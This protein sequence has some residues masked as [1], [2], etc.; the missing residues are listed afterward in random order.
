MKLNISFANFK[1][2]HRNKKDQI[3]F[4]T[5]NCND[6]SKVENL[7]KFLLV[8]KNS[9]IFESVEK[10]KIRG[11]YTIVGLN[12]DKIWNITG[13]SVTYTLEG[14]KKKI[15]ANA[16]RQNPRQLST[17]IDY[18]IV[19]GKIVINKGIHTG[20][21]PGRALKRRNQMI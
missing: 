14:K 9:F 5:K 3:I 4:V 11:R 17:G 19:N 16:S 7:F 1:K 20:L 2:N 8:E 6:Y 12:P 21:L 18:V 15:K 13:N 10:G